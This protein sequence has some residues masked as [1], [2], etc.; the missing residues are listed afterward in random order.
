MSG[1]DQLANVD[2]FLILV[3]RDGRL[4]LGLRGPDVY[5]GGQWNVVSG[6]ADVGE[7]AVTA[8]V[9]E[10][11]E[12][13]GVVLSRD[14]VSPAAVVHYHNLNGLPR[15]GFAF[16]ARHDP[17]RH[18]E[19]AAQRRIVGAEDLV[20]DRRGIAVGE[21][22]V[23]LM[24]HEIAEAIAG[25]TGIDGHRG[26]D[27]VLQIGIRHLDGIAAIARVAVALALERDGAQ[28][29]IRSPPRHAVDGD[30][31]DGRRLDLGRLG[32]RHHEN[33]RRDQPG[34]CGFETLAHS[35]S[36]MRIES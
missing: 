32:R 19:A 1:R 31:V 28:P 18:G 6:K 22:A 5:H 10:A 3:D 11:A 25:I 2:V 13:A 34:G 24:R 20:R 15:V 36:P 29:A 4:L 33:E 23:T 35:C 21:R 16:R 7:D 14:D 26:G 27:A 30:A 8:V 12:E 17:A 9:R